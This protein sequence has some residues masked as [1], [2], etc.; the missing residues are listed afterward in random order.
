MVIAAVRR[1]SRVDKPG[2]LGLV[3]RIEFM[4]VN[5]RGYSVPAGTHEPKD[6]RLG[7]LCG[8]KAESLTA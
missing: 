5:E 4:A 8:R 1:Q 6:K 2:T 3:L 7:Q